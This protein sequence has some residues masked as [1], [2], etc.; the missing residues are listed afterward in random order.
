FGDLARAAAPGLLADLR[1]VSPGGGLVVDL[2]CGSG[3]WARDLCDA[4]YDVLGIDLSESM[5]ALA[6]AREPR[7][8][9]RTGSFLSAEMPPCVAVTALG[10]ILSFLFDEANTGRRLGTFFCRVYAP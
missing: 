4:G 6:R 7:A 2:G 8:T 3:I 5:I 9:F 10:E 1:R